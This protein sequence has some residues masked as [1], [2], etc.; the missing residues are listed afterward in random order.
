MSAGCPNACTGKIALNRPL[1][2]FLPFYLFPFFPFPLFP[3]SP[4]PLYPFFP[5]SPCQ[6]VGCLSNEGRVYVQHPRVNV[7][8]DGDGAFVE[9]D[10][11]GGD[12]G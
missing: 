12:E 7:H 5:L 8:E 4:F 9:D 2:P 11:G 6:L 10:I 3:F 1:L